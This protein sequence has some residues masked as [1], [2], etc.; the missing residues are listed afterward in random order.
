MNDESGRACSPA[1]DASAAGGELILSHA[2]WPVYDF[3]T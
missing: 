2:C 3:T 1:P